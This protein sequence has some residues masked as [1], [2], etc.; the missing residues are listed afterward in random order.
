MESGHRRGGEIV[1]YGGIIP[2]KK[3]RQEEVGMGRQGS[4]NFTCKYA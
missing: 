3:R 1:R 4:F 2:V